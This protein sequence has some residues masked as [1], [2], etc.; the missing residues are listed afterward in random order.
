MKLVD[1]LNRAN[2]GYDDGYLAE[3]FDE[4]TGAK[5]KGSGDGLAKFI[6]DEIT[7]TYDSARPIEEAVRVLE[8]ARRQLDEVIRALE[9]A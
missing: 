7:E 4:K 3:Y 6:V 8:S 2:E 9:G 1:L 5:K